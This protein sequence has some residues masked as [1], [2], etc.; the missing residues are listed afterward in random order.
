MRE[1]VALSAPVY[2]RAGWLPSFT[3][4][5]SGQTWTHTLLVKHVILDIENGRS[6]KLQQI[7]AASNQCSSFEKRLSRKHVFL[8]CMDFLMVT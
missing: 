5:I 7:A 1:Y 6:P 3:W 4:I 2:K 8:A